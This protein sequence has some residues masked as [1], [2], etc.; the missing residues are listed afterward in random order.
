MR[1]RHPMFHMVGECQLSAGLL[2]VTDGVIR[3]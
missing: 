2:A 3:Y 1:M